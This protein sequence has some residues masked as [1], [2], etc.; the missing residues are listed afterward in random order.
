M[1]VLGIV[2][3]PRKGGNSEL[4]VKEILSQLPDSW[5]KEMIRLNELNLKYCTACYSCVPADKQCKLDDDLAFLIER[6]RL[7]DKIAIGCPSYFL[8][9]HTAMKLALDRM[10]S[11]LSNFREFAGKEC[12]LVAPYGLDKWEGAVKEDM[13]IFAAEFNL[14]VVDSAVILATIPGE[15]VQGENLNAVRRLANSL[16]NPPEKPFAPPGEL[17]CPYC[18]S[19]ALTLFEDG[20]WTCRIC[21]GTGRIEYNNGKFSI[22]PDAENHSHFT[23]EGKILHADYL[24]EKKKFFLD[25]RQSVKEIQAKYAGMNYWVSPRA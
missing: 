13:L 21:G 9:S 15:S 7:A 18:T 2:S 17:D 23:P 20:L 10:L 14:K 25:N 6:V 24:M 11:I 8:G 1:K 5:E 12:V 22:K 19:G 4:A 16:M 3:S